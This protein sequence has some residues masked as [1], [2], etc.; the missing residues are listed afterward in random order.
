MQQF[1]LAVGPRNLSKIVAF[2]SALSPTRPWKITVCEFRKERSDDQN[3]ALWGVAYPPLMEFTGFTKEELH[4]HFCRAFFGEVE[5]EIMGMLRMKP[6]RTTTVDENGKKNKI[7]TLEFM[8]FYAFV[9]QKG[10]EIGCYV[11]DPDPEYWRRE[12]AA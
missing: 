8:D 2:L 10:A 9:Q 1:V 3:S 12:L 4:D 5:Y 11:P 7:S 6:R